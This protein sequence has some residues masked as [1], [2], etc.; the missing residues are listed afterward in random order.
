MTDN[1]TLTGA[2]RAALMLAW[3]SNGLQLVHG[4]WT[5]RDGHVTGSSCVHDL[6]R[7]GLFSFHDRGRANLTVA[8]WETVG[9]I[10]NAQA[11]GLTAALEAA[12][13]HGVTS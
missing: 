13:K 8:G 5:G 3:E 7:E 1:L 12:L 9:R 11:S 6:V 10:L 2:Q 4:A